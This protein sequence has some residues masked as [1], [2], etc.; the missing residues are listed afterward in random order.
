MAERKIKSR[1]WNG[2]VQRLLSRHG[3]KLLA[4]DIGIQPIL[5]V[6]H[7]HNVL[8]KSTVPFS[9]DYRH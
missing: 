2:S 4:N 5:L 8:S 3:D 6:C 1:L 9:I 7:L